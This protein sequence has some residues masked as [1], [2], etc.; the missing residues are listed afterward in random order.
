MDQFETIE[1]GELRPALAYLLAPPGGSLAA[2]RSHV[3]A[4]CE[5]L[6]QGAVQW[7]GLRCGRRSA[8][9]GLFF[10]LLL[11]G[12]TAIVMIPTPGD[13]GIVPERQF[14]VARA[15]LDRLAGHN[16]HFAQA[17]LELDAPG[18]RALLERAGFALLAPLIYLERDVAFPWVDPP[19]AGTAEWVRYGAR[20]HAEFA[21]VVLATYEDSLDCPELTGLRPIDDILAAHQASGQFD[22]ALWELARI[23]GQSAGC[24]LVSRVTHAPI[25]E[26]VY[27]GVIAGCRRRGVGELLLRRALEQCRAVGAQRLTVVVDNRNEPAKRLYTRFGFAPLTQRDAYLFRWQP[28][29]AASDA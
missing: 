22:P 29:T 7:E 20:T 28:N 23:D 11:P 4:F 16:L 26:I 10:A 13:H 12:R 25:L 9:T 17:L 18:K 8:P 1:P 21:A 19:A 5:Y 14:A 27:M 3:P 15:G 2:A 24:I 6:A